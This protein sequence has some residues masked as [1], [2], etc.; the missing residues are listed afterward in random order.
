M[1]YVYGMR[2]RGFSIGC[3]PMNGLIK[4]I[5]DKT[6]CYYDILIYDRKLVGKEKTNFELDFLNQT[7]YV[8]G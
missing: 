3:Q 5:D 7:R 8:G 1:Y 2:N 6:G 4:R